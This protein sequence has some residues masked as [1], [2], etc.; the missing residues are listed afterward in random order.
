MITFANGRGLVA[1]LLHANVRSR[2]LSISAN[3]LGFRPRNQYTSVSL[4]C[5]GELPVVPGRENRP[6]CIKSGGR[7]NPH[8]WRVS[9]IPRELV[10]KPSRS[11]D[12]VGHQTLYFCFSCFAVRNLIF[13]LQRLLFG[14]RPPPPSCMQ[15]KCKRQFP[16]CIREG[17]YKSESDP[18]ENRVSC[19]G[20]ALWRRSEFV[21]LEIRPREGKEPMMGCIYSSYQPR[22]F[23][24]VVWDG[25]ESCRAP[26]VPPVLMPTCL[27]S[28]RRALRRDHRARP[29]PF[30]NRTPWKMK[31]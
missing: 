8:R 13:R 29:P 12:I 27:F 26:Y 15:I 5:R 18:D 21:S 24:F 6:P 7:A 17:T 31:E 16:W 30:K 9:E 2:I 10:R 14:A 23:A 4:R 3:G 20:Q 28:F 19:S 1:H 25:M 22:R 11:R